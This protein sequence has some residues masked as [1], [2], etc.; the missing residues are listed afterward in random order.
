MYYEKMGWTYTELYNLPV[1]LRRYFYLKL[2]KIRK[3]GSKIR[4]EG[5]NA[6][7]DMATLTKEE[8]I[9]LSAATKIPEE[10]LEIYRKEAA[11]AMIWGEPEET[12]IS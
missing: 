10:R 3:E 12:T 7:E 1:Y 11:D 5:I 9:K 4:E 6:I 8:K 2:A